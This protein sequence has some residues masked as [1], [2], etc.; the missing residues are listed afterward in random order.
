MFKLTY[1]VNASCFDGYLLMA[2]TDKTVG[3]TV[4][5]TGRTGL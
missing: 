3:E 2:D 1:D 5:V 4:A